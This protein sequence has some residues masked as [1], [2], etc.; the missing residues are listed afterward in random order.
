MK[1]T[2]EE[3]N[4]DGRYFPSDSEMQILIHYLQIYFSHP[5]RS[6]QRSQVVQTVVGIL[7]ATN[8]HWSHRTVR[9]WFNNNKR[10]FLRP[11]SPSSSSSSSSSQSPNQTSSQSS[12]QETNNENNSTFSPQLK[13]FIPT[14]SLSVA[15]LPTKLEQERQPIV[16]PQ[17]APPQTQQPKRGTLALQFSIENENILQNPNHLYQSQCESE[18]NITNKIISLQDKKWEQLV[19]VQQSRTSLIDLTSV[20]PY[21]PQENDNSQ[22]Q[23]KLAECISFDL[24]ETS[25]ISTTGESILVSYDN[26]TGSQRLHFHERYCEVGLLS[27]VSSMV[28]NESDGL[29]WVHSDSFIK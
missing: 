18:A 21:E 12:S 2:N 7:S 8:K 28:Y 25:S 26:E 4:K 27:P 15:Q 1:S 16:S 17:Y 29:I 23:P 6:I 22:R 20:P 11:S 14:R 19:G 10:V 5:E 24:I 3:E 13:F 9:L